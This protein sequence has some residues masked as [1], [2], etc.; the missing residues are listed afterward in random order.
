MSLKHDIEKMQETLFQQLPAQA[1]VKLA[2]G[3]QELVRSG[4]ADKALKKGDKAPAFSLPAVTGKLIHSTELLQKGP[5][6][7][8]FY[9]GG[10]CPYCD[11]ELRALQRVLND[12]ET[13]GAQL[14]VISPQIPEASRATSDDRDLQFEVLSD[15]GNTVAR[16][17]G[18]VF[19][20]DRE[21]KELYLT[22]DIDLS[23]ANGNDSGELPI[24]ATYIIAPDNTIIYSY[25]NA[26]YTQRAEPGDII[27]AIKNI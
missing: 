6:V 13:L 17:F 12:I 11:L 2:T 14:V 10:W 1:V 5:L 18:L 22:L 20:L 27:A 8:S 4:I 7:V 19:T 15:V 3:R 16:A 24:P 9:R 26:D 23:A 25:V 21:L